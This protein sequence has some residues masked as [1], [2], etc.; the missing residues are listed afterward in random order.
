M[1]VVSSYN[2]PAARRCLQPLLPLLERALPRTKDTAEYL[3]IRVSVVASQPLTA[4]GGLLCCL[5]FDVD[6]WGSWLRTATDRPILPSASKNNTVS[7]G[8]HQH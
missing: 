2:V 7:S 6:C 8:S 5:V 4:A 1:A 3:Q